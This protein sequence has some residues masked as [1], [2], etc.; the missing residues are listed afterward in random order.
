MFPYSEPI[1]AGTLRA[2][3]RINWTYAGGRQI[4]LRGAVE[5]LKLGKHI[6][7]TLRNA[8]RIA[9]VEPDVMPAEAVEKL[10]S[11][12]IELWIELARTDLHHLWSE[13]AEA[14]AIVRRRVESLRD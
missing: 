6:I 12:L 5:Q 11:D 10:T 14:D 3:E 7:E 13:H 4:L 8:L 1:F 9:A 2:V